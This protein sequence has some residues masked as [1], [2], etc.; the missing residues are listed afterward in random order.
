MNR[1]RY[2]VILLKLVNIFEIIVS[3]LLIAG[4]IISIPDILKYYFKIL[5]SDATLSYEIFQNFLSHVL[6]LVIAIEFVV[7]M[8]AHTDTNILHLIL[9]VISRK[10]LVYSDTMLDLLFAT[11]AIA[12]LF[13][14]RKYLLT[15]ARIENEK[16]KY[17]EF[18]A[19]TTIKRLNSKYGFEI[20]PKDSKTIGGYVYALLV[21]NAEEPEIGVIVDD[22]KCI[23]QIM[24][25]SSGGVIETVSI[26]KIDKN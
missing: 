15:G 26:E 3:I 2:L 16:N 21:K 13:A 1:N 4:V 23:Y 7:L 10:M 17:N 24:S 12:I 6:L 25:M 19:T 8:I 9:L 22:G 14:V 11:T 18:S 20:D 5:T